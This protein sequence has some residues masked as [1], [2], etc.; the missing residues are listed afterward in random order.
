M[1][2]LFYALIAVLVVGCKTIETM[3]PGSE[4]TLKEV[5]LDEF[6]NNG[7]SKS[8]PISFAIPEEYIHAELDAPMTYSY[9]MPSEK[10]QTA[11]D[12]KDMPTDTGWIYGKVT[13]SVGYDE[14]SDKFIGADNLEQQAKMGGFTNVI[15]ERMEVGGY[16][17]LTLEMK[18]EKSGKQIY[19]MY[20]GMKLETNTIYLAYRAPKSEEALGRYVWSNLKSTMKSNQSLQ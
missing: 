13:L 5:T 1:K 2:N 16:P 4:P 8:I 20:I 11:R 14:K 15:S 3:A 12:S 18:H 7:L 10:V 17:I 9:W 19:S 6:M